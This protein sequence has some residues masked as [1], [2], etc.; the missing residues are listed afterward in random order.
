M[1]ILVAY[2]GSDCAKAAMDDLQLGGL[3]TNAKALVLAVAEGWPVL[4][5]G[6]FG[7]LGEQ[8]VLQSPQA[9]ESAAVLADDAMDEAEELSK[10]GADRLKAL[11]PGWEIEARASGGG[12]AHTIIETAEAFPADMVVVGSHGRSAVERLFFGSVSQKVARYAPCGVRVARGRS[13]RGDGPPRLV[14]GFDGSSESHAAVSAVAQRRWPAGTQAWVLTALDIRL[15]ATFPT[16]GDGDA[17]KVVERQAQAAA[18]MLRDAGLESACELRPGYPNRLLIQESQAKDADCLFVGARG[19]T[20]LERFLM[21]TVSS[22]V[23]GRAHC[24]VEVIREQVTKAA[25][26]VVG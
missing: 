23:I 3:P 1:N 20:R 9:V 8:G 5:S 12:A 26:K 11:F 16:F 18:A 19:V 24:S 21:G 22:A 2:D 7:T 10:E 13:D 6:T 14:I 15:S 25:A 17:I 4:T